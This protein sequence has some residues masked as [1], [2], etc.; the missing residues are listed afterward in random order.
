MIGTRA[1]TIVLHARDVDK[2][3]QNDVAPWSPIKQRT[4]LRARN[5]NKFESS[6]W[7]TLSVGTMQNGELY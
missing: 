1:S 5:F 6:P 2:N 3:P 7:W 4:W